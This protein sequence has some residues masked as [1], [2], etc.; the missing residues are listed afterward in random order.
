MQIFVMTINNHESEA[1]QTSNDARAESWNC[2]NTHKLL[3]FE[4]YSH[5]T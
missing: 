5:A 2:H 4:S 3:F 1:E